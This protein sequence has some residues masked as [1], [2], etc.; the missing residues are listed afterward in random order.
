MIHPPIYIYINIF[1]LLLHVACC[2]LL[3]LHIA[4]NIA[5]M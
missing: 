3:I 5:R 4:Y 2:L 1:I